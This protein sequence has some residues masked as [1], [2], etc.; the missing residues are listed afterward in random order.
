MD[1]EQVIGMILEEIRVRNKEVVAK[2]PLCAQIFTLTEED[3]QK[4][5]ESLYQFLLRNGS[6]DQKEGLK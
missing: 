4:I 3:E 1:K 2:S 6:L 5:A